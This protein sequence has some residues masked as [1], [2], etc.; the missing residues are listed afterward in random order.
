MASVTFSEGF[1]PDQLVSLLGT[2]REAGVTVTEEIGDGPDTI[3]LADEGGDAIVIKGQFE[4]DEEGELHGTL[5]QIAILQASAVVVTVSDFHDANGHDIVEGL[6][7]ALNSGGD[8][9]GE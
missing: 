2:M 1:T 4:L 8:G 9:P 5:T 7:A 3:T 6:E